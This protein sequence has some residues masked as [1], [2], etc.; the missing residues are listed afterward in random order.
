MNWDSR[1]AHSAVYDAEQTAE[2][3]C[4]IVNRWKRLEEFA[5]AAPP[6]QSSEVTTTVVVTETTVSSTD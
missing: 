4:R 3:F 1:E 6:L 2:L 5:A